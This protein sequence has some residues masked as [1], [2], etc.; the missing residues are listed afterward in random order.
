MNIIENAEKEC[1]V[2]G[3]LFQ[4]IINEMKV[5]INIDDNIQLLPVRQ[6]RKM[7]KKLHLFNKRHHRGD[8]S[9]PRSLLLH[10]SAIVAHKGN[11]DH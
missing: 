2:L 9:M 6:K 8:L 3:T 4:G 11:N 7:K 1:A 10:A 5:R